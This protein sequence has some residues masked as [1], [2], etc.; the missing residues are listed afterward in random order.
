MISGLAKRLKTSRTK[1]G[2]SRKEAAELIGITE[3]AIGQYESGTKQPALYTL[4]RLASVYNVSTDYLLG[5]NTKDENNISLE[6]LSD[7]Q[8]DAVRMI[9]KCFRE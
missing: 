7:E 2:L 6:G 8:K 1:A 3:S 4:I 9:V 5:C